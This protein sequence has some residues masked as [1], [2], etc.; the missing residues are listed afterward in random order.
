MEIKIFDREGAK[1]ARKI[2]KASPGDSSPG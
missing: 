1:N 2:M